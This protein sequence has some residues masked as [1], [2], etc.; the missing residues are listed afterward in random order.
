[1]KSPTPNRTIMQRVTIIVPVK[2]EENGLRYLLDDLKSSK[3]NDD[4]EIEFIF[5]IDERTTDNSKKIASRFSEHIIDQNTTQGKG[6]A[7]RQAIG[8]FRGGSSEFV[9]FLDADGSYSFASVREIIHSL[10]QGADVVS[11]SRFLDSPRRPMGMSRLHNFGNRTLSLISSIR[12]GHKISDLCTGLWGFTSEVI[13]KIEIKSNGFDLEAEIAGIC[14]KKG[15]THLEIP[16]DWSQR[17]GGAS[18]LR[19][20]SD[21]FVILLRIIRT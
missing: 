12:N 18:K 8:E 3:I 21:G 1:V 19:S 11:G 5:V 7:I 17:K 13:D 6:S 20:F 10:I 16:V 14:R 2:D 4:F 9:V 15:L